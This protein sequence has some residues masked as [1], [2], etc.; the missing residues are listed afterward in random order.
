M[1]NNWQINW[2]I[3]SWPHS[4]YNF[5]GLQHSQTEVWKWLVLD[6]WTIPLHHEGNISRNWSLQSIFSSSIYN[7]WD[8][9]FSLCFIILTF[10]PVQ[11]VLQCLQWPA[12]RGPLL[13]S[14]QFRITLCT[15]EA[16]LEAT[17]TCI[18]ARPELGS[19]TSS[20]ST[21]QG[22]PCTICQ[23][24]IHKLYEYGDMHHHCTIT[25]QYKLQCN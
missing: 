16:R 14:I 19:T 22:T 3:Y 20:L 15:P 12:P 10:K 8:K 11:Q 17:T 18:P 25:L 24:R 6:P 23:A 5:R 9:I 4:V 13:R 21:R 2:N 1:F 7:W